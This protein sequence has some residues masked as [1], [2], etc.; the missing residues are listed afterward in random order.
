MLREPYGIKRR[1]EAADVFKAK[2][3]PLF[4]GSECFMWL[5]KE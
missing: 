4:L 2:N 3:L 1:L 5:I